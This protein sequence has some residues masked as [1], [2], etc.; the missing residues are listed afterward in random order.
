M[1]RDSGLFQLGIS[2]LGVSHENIIRQPCCRVIS[3][4]FLLTGVEPGLGTP[5]SL[6]VLHMVFLVWLS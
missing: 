5:T 4:A 3:K 6:V 2:G 1:V